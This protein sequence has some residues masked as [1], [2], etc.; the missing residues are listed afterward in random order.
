MVTLVNKNSMINNRA[1]TELKNSTLTHRLLGTGQA[2]FPRTSVMSRQFLTIPVVI[3]TGECEF[4]FVGLTP[5]R[6]VQI[7][8]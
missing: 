7:T 8:V 3:A 4:S 1:E 6:P 2:R 5:F